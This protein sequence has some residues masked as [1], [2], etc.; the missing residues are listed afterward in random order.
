[1]N[2][3]GWQDHLATPYLL[4]AIGEPCLKFWSLGPHL[5]SDLKFGWRH[6]NQTRSHLQQSLPEIPS[7]SQHRKIVNV[8]HHSHA[9]DGMH[10]GA[11]SSHELHDVLIS[12]HLFHVPLQDFRRVPKAVHALCETG[13][14]SF[15]EI[16]RASSSGKSMNTSRFMLQFTNASLRPRVVSDLSS[17]VR[18]IDAQTSWLPSHWPGVARFAANISSHQPAVLLKPWHTNLFLKLFVLTEST[19]LTPR[20]WAPFP[21]ILRTR[22]SHVLSL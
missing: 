11:L 3:T 7:P 20:T 14:Q 10:A 13:P 12:K 8:R 1:M 18:Q 15:S 4:F 16:F 17:N 19:H 9:R 2:D 6:R 22:T 5:P 21:K